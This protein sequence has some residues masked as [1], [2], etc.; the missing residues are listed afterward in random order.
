MDILDQLEFIMLNDTSVIQQPIADAMKEIKSLRAE[1]ERL[2]K[3]AEWISVDD[4]LPKDGDFVY[5][6]G[7]VD[8]E[9]IGRSAARFVYS[10]KWCGS[11][12][13]ILQHIP[14]E[15][16]KPPTMKQ[17]DTTPTATK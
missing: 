9:I 3:D 1:V 14:F 10:G 2:R 13:N 15:K 17:D 8:S 7:F 12:I 4:R 16:P 5:G 11:H 6:Y